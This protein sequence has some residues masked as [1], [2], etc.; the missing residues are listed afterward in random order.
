MNSVPSSP[1]NDTF[2]GAFHWTLF[3]VVLFAGLA[4]RFW[5]VTQCGLSM[6]D[7]YSYVRAARWLSTIGRDGHP[8]APDV[9]P[10]LYPVWVAICFLIAGYHD[11]VAIAASATASLLTLPALYVL[12]SRL[13]G[14]SAALVAAAFLATNPF[15]I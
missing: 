8:L 6:W 3:A 12:G 15:N 2:S 5:R 14:P 13:Y 9:A 10:P 4:L 1:E 7:E 11:W